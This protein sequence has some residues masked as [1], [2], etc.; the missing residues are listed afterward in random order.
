MSGRGL[1]MRP[2][3]LEEAHDRT[4]TRNLAGMIHAESTEATD[5]F[6]NQIVFDINVIFW[7]EMSEYGSAFRKWL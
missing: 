2:T 7:F 4:S 6:L 1:L 5:S 3:S